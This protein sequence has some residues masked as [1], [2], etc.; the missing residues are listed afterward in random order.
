MITLY[1][2]G[3]NT[4]AIGP[5]F[6]T[7]WSFTNIVNPTDSFNI[8]N[9]GGYS[10]YITADYSDNGH[11]ALIGIFPDIAY[12]SSLQFTV[13]YSI[14][15]PNSN[16]HL[17]TDTTTGVGSVALQNGN[18]IAS[19]PASMTSISYNNV[20][21]DSI[22]KLYVEIPSLD[23]IHIHYSYIK[24]EAD[25]STSIVNE[26]TLSDVIVFSKGNRVFIQPNCSGNLLVNLYDLTGSKIS[27]KGFFGQT[28]LDLPL[29]ASGIYLTEIISEN[30]RVV[31]K[32]VVE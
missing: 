6:Y 17:F 7:S 10:R 28:F 8:D 26:H 20:D 19:D 16:L 13:G 14:S 24:I 4:T 9:Q 11:F 32:V 31:K 22:F 21:G 29:S 18:L 5:S 12:Y 25:I 2:F 30:R 23:S 3:N 1:E 27:S 15:D